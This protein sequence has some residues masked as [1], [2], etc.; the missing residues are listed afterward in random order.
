MGYDARISVN[1]WRKLVLEYTILNG[2]SIDKTARC[3]SIS[4]LRQWGDH[5]SHI[6]STNSVHQLDKRDYS[7]ID[8]LISKKRTTPVGAALESGR[9]RMD[10]IC[11]LGVEVLIL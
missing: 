11:G 9:P 2:G 10:S 1:Y 4:I 5:Q 6:K 7:Q 3:I 8:S